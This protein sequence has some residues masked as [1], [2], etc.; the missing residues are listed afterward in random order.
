MMANH[1]SGVRVTFKLGVLFI[2]ITMLLVACYNKQ[3]W[4]TKN[5]TGLM[6]PL[7]FSMTESNS[8]KVVHAQNYRGHIVLLYF[9]Y[10]HCPDVCPLTLRRIKSALTQLG[11]TAKDTR[12]LFV[13]VD[14]AR[15]SKAI[16]KSYTQYY[17]PQFL[18]LHASQ[19]AL[20]ELTKRYRVTYGYDHPDKE[21]NYNVSHSSAIYVFDRKGQARLLIRPSDT[22]TAIRSDLERLLDQS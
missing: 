3:P 14:P 13:S 7:M 22:V 16:L 6:Q 20:Q 1:Y 8:D 5:I 12:V 4:A 21:G 11:N 19:S 9:G 10:T 2:F 17:G 18:G 15:D